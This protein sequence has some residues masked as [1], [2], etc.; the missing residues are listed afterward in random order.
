MPSHYNNYRTIT[1]DSTM[2]RYNI[3]HHMCRVCVRGRGCPFHSIWCVDGSE[4]HQPHKKKES[5]TSRSQLAIAVASLSTNSPRK[6][7]CPPRNAAQTHTARDRAPKLR[8]AYPPPGQRVH[9]S[10]KLGFHAPDWQ[11]RF[12]TQR[13][14]SQ[15]NRGCFR[16]GV[17]FLAQPPANI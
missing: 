3:S 13:L 8:R 9:R 12:A 2:Y 4:H 6:G 17:T 1:L 14:F 10:R 5:C 7:C 15:L 11:W 16:V